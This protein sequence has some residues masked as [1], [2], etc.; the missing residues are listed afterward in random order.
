[1]VTVQV[2]VPVPV[3][4]PLTQVRPDREAVLVPFPWSLIVLE[5]FVE[6]LLIALILNWLV[7]ST[8]FFGMNC[9][10]TV[11]LLPAA[12]LTGRVP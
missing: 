6:V 4:E 9:T 2:S 8:V 11:R 10:L 12:R 1:M 3:I 5:S 7:E